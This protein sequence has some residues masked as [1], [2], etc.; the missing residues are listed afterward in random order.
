MSLVVLIPAAGQSVRMRGRDKLLEEIDGVPLLA[1]Q[2]AAVLS[3]G[4]PVLVTLPAQAQDRINALCACRDDRLTVMNIAD[5]DEGLSASIRMGATWAMAQGADALMVALPD[6][7]DLSR[8]DFKAMKEAHQKHPDAIIR[9]T[10]AKGQPGHPTILPARLLEFL[11]K[12]T[13]DTGAKSIV[14]TEGFIPCPLPG[15]R[16]ITDLDTPEAWAEWRAARGP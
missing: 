8:D 12:L 13:G 3:L 11:T 14:E 6:L 15:D 7:P 16:A 2:T 5:A 4:C 10:T 1:R 9:A